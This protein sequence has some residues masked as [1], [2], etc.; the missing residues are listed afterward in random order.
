MRLLYGGTFDPPHRGHMGVAAAAL[1]E[2]EVDELI[3]APVGDPPHRQGMLLPARTRH[4]LAVLAFADLPATVSEVDL[5]RSPA[6]AVDTLE[7]LESAHGGGPVSLL[8]GADQLVGLDG[9]H[10]W[11]DLVRGRTIVVAPRPAQ[12]A[13]PALAAAGRVVEEAG[14]RVHVLQGAPPD[15]DATSLRAAIREGDWGLVADQV[16]PAVLEVLRHRAPARSQ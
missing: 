9:W 11:R 15:I 7:S 2:L 1:D 4:E 12:V 14:G 10:R 6:Y 5:Q 8:V 13:A 16:A 3:V